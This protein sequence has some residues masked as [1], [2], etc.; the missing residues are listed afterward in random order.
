MLSAAGVPFSAIASEIDEGAVKLSLADT[1]APGTA[2]ALAERKAVQV[3]TNNP[4][5]LV[6]GSDSIVALKN[7][8]SLDKPRDRAEAADHLRRMRGSTHDIWSA[9]VIAEDGRTVWSHVERAH[10]HV[11]AFS[12]EFLESYLDTEWPAIAWCVGCY[13]IEA[14]G[15][16]LFERIEGS[17]FTVLGLPL[18][19]V[20]GYLRARRVVPT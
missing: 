10:M 19:A 18:L 14:S 2:G 1:S 6:L 9:A 17:Q 3:S 7:G 15:A 12:D 20:L 8:T 5:T 4:G 16:Q 11:R 13:R